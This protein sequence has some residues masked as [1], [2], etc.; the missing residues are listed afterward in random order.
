VLFNPLVGS[1]DKFLET[2]KFAFK[3]F[4]DE[5]I[6]QLKRVAAAEAAK[7]IIKLISDLIYAGS[8]NVAGDLA[9][10]SG[11]TRAIGNAAVGQANFGGIRGNDGVNMSGQVV[12][13]LRGTDLVG[14]M[15]RTN[16]SI[17][18]VG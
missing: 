1:F 2:G 12:M 5:A 3:E 10:K 18:R 16:T 11:L 14:A 4:A 9:E 17:N 7:L 6:K 13:T 8:G 15:N